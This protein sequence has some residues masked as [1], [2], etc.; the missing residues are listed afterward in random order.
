MPEE[1]E[2]QK[3]SAIWEEDSNDLVPVILSKKE[4][5]RLDKIDEEYQKQVKANKWK[6]SK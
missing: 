2:E 3:Q 6:R 4:S 5:E 1:V